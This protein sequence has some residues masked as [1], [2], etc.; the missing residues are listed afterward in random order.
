MISR[1]RR[2]RA[3]RLFRRA[4]NEAWLRARA[5]PIRMALAQAWL[6]EQLAFIWLRGLLI[7]YY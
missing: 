3:M 5:R 7:K 4:R 6:D 2:A 1:A